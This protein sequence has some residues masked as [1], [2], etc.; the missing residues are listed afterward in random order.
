MDG[1]IAARECRKE[2]RRSASRREIRRLQMDPEERL[3]RAAKDSQWPRVTRQ[4]AIEFSTAN[5]C[6][7]SKVIFTTMDR[8]RVRQLISV[9]D[10]PLRK[11]KDIN[12]YRTKTGD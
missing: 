7:K 12:P 1:G 8:N 5:I 11:I 3:R 4:R 2:P 6:P 10:T 9:I